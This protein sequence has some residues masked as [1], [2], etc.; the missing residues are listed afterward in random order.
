MAWCLP[1]NEVDKFK[2]AILSRRIDP[3]RLAEM[4]SKERRDLFARE[5]GEI[6]ASQINAE[7][8][9]KLLLKNQQAGYI[10]WAKKMLGENTPAG[11]DVISRI[12]RMDKILEA[13]DE[14]LFL[15]DLAGKR[16]GTQVT[17]DEAKQ[18]ADLSK[19]ID[20]AKAD[21]EKG[22]DRLAYGMSLVNLRNYVGDLKTKAGRMSVEDIKRQPIRSAGRVVWTGLQTAKA[23][24]A[25]WDLSAMFR[26]GIKVAL[27][28]PKV[29][30]RNARK[31]FQDVWNTYG[32][33]QVT[34][35]VNADI[36]S[37]ENA[38]NGYYK[39]GKVDLGI[40]E[41]AHPTDV[42]ERV[43]EYLG[44]KIEATKVPVV[45]KVVGR[46]VGKTYKA[47]QDAY[48]AFNTRTRA[49]LFDK[50]VD[51]AKKSGQEMDTEIL[52]SIGRMTNSLVGRGRMGA[53]EPVSQYINVPFFSPKMLKSHIDVL[54]EPLSGG[55]GGFFGQEGG[56][57]FAR[58]E[59]AKNLLKIIG[60]TAAILGVAKVINSDSVDFDPRSA[61]NGK[62]RV[63]DT[64]FDVTGGW[65]SI[66]TLASRLATMKTKSS[67]TGKIRALNE[68]DDEG[69]LKYKT[70]TAKDL[71]YDFFENKY[72]P[73]FAVARDLAKGETRSGERPTAMTSLRDLYEPLPLANYRELRD[74]PNS[75]PKL[76]AMIADGL[77]IATNTYSAKPSA[78]FGSKKTKASD[79]VNRLDI[80]LRGARRQ[81]TESPEE[82]KVREERENRYIKKMIEA[83]V[84]LPEYDNETD[85]NKVEWLKKAKE[86]AVKDSNKQK[87][88]PREPLKPTDFPI[89]AVNYDEKPAP[90]SFRKEL[91]KKRPNTFR[92]WLQTTA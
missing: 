23:V 89:P 90:L 18:I 72:S 48:S 75:A 77:G 12:Q 5:L 21:M 34:D 37:R 22:G 2:K 79:E 74:N 54:L 71:I 62:I 27:T 73:P 63:G 59:A 24:K 11:R 32:G 10:N 9:S 16:L 45:S 36:L 29:W 65:A 42:P 33:K 38:L 60:G 19:R 49:D 80:D 20:T 30:Q 78:L 4:S 52:E 15:E 35:A 3:E 50:Y 43:S 92:Q 14:Q 8:E 64:R 7:F 56:T 31:Q 68:R 61:N 1:P 76:L 41:E 91:I 88:E 6:N 28:H 53:L 13:T 83:V 39:K 44:K 86:E 84:A 55:G 25:A 69:K 47:S 51:I 67:T 57:N 70:Q 87:L 26:P 40:T 17:F 46:A 58:K 85:E 82:F 66:V 81:P